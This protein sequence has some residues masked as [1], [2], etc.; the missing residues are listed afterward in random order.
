MKNIELKIIE[1]DQE[2]TMAAEM[3]HKG[4]KVMGLDFIMPK[5]RNKADIFKEL[6]ITWTELAHAYGSAEGINETKK[7]LIKEYKKWKTSKS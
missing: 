7:E 1:K 5:D 3:L 2:N 4:K 6:L